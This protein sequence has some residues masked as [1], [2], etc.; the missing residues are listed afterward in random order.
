MLSK[1]YHQSFAELFALIRQQNEERQI[2]GPESVL[3]TRVLLEDEPDKLD[4]LKAY[5][6]QAEAAQRLGTL[7]RVYSKS[8]QFVF[9]R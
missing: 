1:G 5:L 8:G 7:Y 4:V 6:N 3:W 2:A 9:C